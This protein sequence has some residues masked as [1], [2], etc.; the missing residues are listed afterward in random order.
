MSFDYSRIAGT[1]EKLILNFGRAIT[2]RQ[3]S[4]SGT[5]YAPT[6]TNTDTEVTGVGLNFSD[7]EING[8]SIKQG[9]IKY[10]IKTSLVIDETSKIVDGGN[11]YAVVNSEKIKPGDTLVLYKLQARSDG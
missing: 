9:D 4:R 11:V 8:T 6:I 10:L 2:V 1:A 3:T 5:A 7:A